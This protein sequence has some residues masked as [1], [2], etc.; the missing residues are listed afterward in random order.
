MVYIIWTLPEKISFCLS[1]SAFWFPPFRLSHCSHLIVSLAISASIPPWTE[2][3]P[4]Q[5]THLSRLP[6]GCQLFLFCI[7]QVFFLSGIGNSYHPE[8]IGPSLSPLDFPNKFNEGIFAPTFT[9][10]DVAGRL[11]KLKDFRGKIVLLNFWATWWTWCRKEMP[12]VVQ[13]YHEF[14]NSDFVV[15]AINVQENREVGK[16]G[17]R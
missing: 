15:L 9:I 4:F 12:S 10:D 3:A 5:T 2:A 11:V 14:K 13:M 8:S 7:L 17:R 16:I 6:L 1:S